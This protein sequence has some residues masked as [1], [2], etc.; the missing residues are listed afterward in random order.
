LQKKISHSKTVRRNC[1][2]W[3]QQASTTVFD[4][5]RVFFIQE[6]PRKRFLE[7]ILDCDCSALVYRLQ[8]LREAIG[9]H[10]SLLVL[11]CNC[12]IVFNCLKVF[13][14]YECIGFTRVGV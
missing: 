12:N 11:S 7:L 4:Y 3:A 13:W 2:L 1:E 14:V 5:Q 8:A 6:E 9:I 10:S